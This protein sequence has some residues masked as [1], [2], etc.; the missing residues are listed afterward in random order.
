M[1]VIPSSF[2]PHPGSSGG[3]TSKGP[4]SL[5]SV[6]Q[7]FA[8]LVFVFSLVGAAGVYLYS[9]S[10]TS[11]L[12]SD[13]TALQQKISSLDQTTIESLLRLQSRL[14]S[15]KTLLNNHVAFSGIFDLLESI[16]PV[17]V[18]F[19]SVNISY[20]GVGQTTLTASGVAKDF[21]TLAYASNYLGQDPQLKNAIFSGI[22][23][24]NKD[25]TVSFSLS[26]TLNPKLIVYTVPTEAA[27][28]A[29]AAAASSGQAT[30]PVVPPLTSGTSTASTTP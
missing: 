11:Q 28:A 4:F 19:S 25:G 17:N 2:V 6:L 3:G 1:A 26:A 13:D 22:A 21:N 8:Y 23:I 14:V 7:V 18:R 5:A 16:T 9:A 12:A 24:N 10:L 29:P 30:T 15:A 20:D 27:A